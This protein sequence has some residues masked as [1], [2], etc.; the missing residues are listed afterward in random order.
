MIYERGNQKIVFIDIP[1]TGGVVT[2]DVLTALGFSK[3]PV[4]K[5]KY[6]VVPRHLTYKELQRCVWKED[7][8]E[9]LEEYFSFTF[10]RNPYTRM[11]SEWDK[12]HRRM[13]FS[14]FITK[15]PEWTEDDIQVHNSHLRPQSNFTWDGVR[16]S[17]NRIGRYENYVGDLISILS[18]VGFM[19]EQ[20][21]VILP[22]YKTYGSP[23]V[24]RNNYN[25]DTITTMI[26]TYW[27]DLSWFDYTL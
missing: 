27:K 19:K 26:Q 24:D 2:D 9:D 18:D 15:I 12:Y 21:P 13:P 25:Y 22:P 11:Y 5:N 10:V 14:E 17:V 3:I 23:E 16:G 4:K 20:L 7:S 6:D 1:R 8:D